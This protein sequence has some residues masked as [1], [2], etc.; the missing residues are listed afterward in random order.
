M[1]MGDLTAP[2]LQELIDH[3]DVCDETRSTGKNRTQRIVIYPLCWVYRAA[4]Q[5]IPQGRPLQSRHPPRRG[6]GI[7]PQT[8]IKEKAG[9]RLLLHEKKIRVVITSNPLLPL[10]AMLPGAGFE[11]TTSGL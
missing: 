10:D 9:A 2:L 3:I 4:R 11:P 6:G 5:R 8:G 1:E 7:Y